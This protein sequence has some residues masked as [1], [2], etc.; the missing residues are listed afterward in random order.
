MA[1][2]SLSA[3]DSTKRWTFITL[4]PLSR[5]S[6]L[7]MAISLSFSHLA[8]FRQPPFLSRKRVISARRRND[9]MGRETVTQTL[10]ASHHSFSLHTGLLLLS[11]PSKLFAYAFTRTGPCHSSDAKQSTSAGKLEP[12]RQKKRGKATKDEGERRM[13]LYQ[14]ICVI[15]DLRPAAAAFSHI[16]KHNCDS[17]MLCIR[18]PTRLLR[19]NTTHYSRHVFLLSSSSE[20]K[21]HHPGIEVGVAQNRQ[22]R[23]RTHLACRKRLEIRTHFL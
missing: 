18:R 12:F 20:N 22:K 16:K 11:F 14:T 13:A 8:S 10:V 6:S 3:G 9:K 2:S 1:R 23:K 5:R 21:F 4:G 17:G 7:G 19:V 15:R